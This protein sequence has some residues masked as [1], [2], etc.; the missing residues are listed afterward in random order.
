MCSIWMFHSYTEKRWDIPTRQG[1]CDDIHHAY[2]G[3]CWGN[4]LAWSLGRSG[5]CIDKDQPYGIRI[6]INGIKRIIIEVIVYWK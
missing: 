3:R 5:L 2:K 1:V 4:F 6:G